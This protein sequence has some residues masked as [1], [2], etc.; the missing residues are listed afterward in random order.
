MAAAVKGVVAMAVVVKAMEARTA[1]WQVVMAVV[2]VVARLLLLMAVAVAV[3]LLTTVAVMVLAIIKVVAARED[4][5]GIG[6]CKGS[7]W[8][9]RLPIAGSNSSMLI[10]AVPAMTAVSEQTSRGW[11]GDAEASSSWPRRKRRAWASWAECLASWAPKCVH[12][13]YAPP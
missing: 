12:L 6:C 9:S 11:R 5:N 8:K 2:A 7:D 10:I 13:V 1:S 3:A 4:E